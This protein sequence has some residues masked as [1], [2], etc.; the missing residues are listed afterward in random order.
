MHLD[1]GC[2]FC[3]SHDGDTFLFALA[4]PPYIAVECARC[5]GRG[6][7][8]RNKDQALELWDRRSDPPE[9]E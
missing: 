5:L 7:T 8:A 9:R 3:G 4:E 6:P 1:T 2:P